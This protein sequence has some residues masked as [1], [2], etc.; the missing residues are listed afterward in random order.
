MKHRYVVS[1]INT[2]GETVFKA[3]CVAI[4]IIEAI[5]M[6]RDIGFS[7]YEIKRCEQ[8]SSNIKNNIIKII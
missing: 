3:E 7:V 8:V 5:K 4:D 2:H 6:F 1:G